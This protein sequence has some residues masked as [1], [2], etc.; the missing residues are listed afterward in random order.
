M[1]SV[2]ILC[3]QLALDPSCFIE[4]CTCRTHEAYGKLH[5][6]SELFPNV[7]LMVTKKWVW[8][9]AHTVKATP[10]ASSEQGGQHRLRFAFQSLGGNKPHNKKTAPL[11]DS[12]L[13][14]CSTIEKSTKGSVGWGSCITGHNNKPKNK[15][16][17]SVPL[18]TADLSPSQV[19]E[20]CTISNSL[21]TSCLLSTYNLHFI[22]WEL[23]MCKCMYT[24]VVCPLQQDVHIHKS[25]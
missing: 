13:T 1:Q 5:F 11:M 7:T 24:L 14:L 4:N 6:S 8:R 18:G 15:I 19:T 17:T 3:K 22:P 25:K 20:N 12:D 2:H 10:W 16:K 21:V 23:Y 9:P